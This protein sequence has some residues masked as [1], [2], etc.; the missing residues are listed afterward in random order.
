M[1]RPTTLLRLA[2]PSDEALWRGALAAHGVTAVSLPDDARSLLDVIAGDARLHGARAMVVDL[3][4]LD[5]IGHVPVRLAARLT[6]LHPDLRVFAR[7]P[8]RARACPEQRDWARRHGFAG[9]L[10]GNSARHAA[11]LVPAL[12]E[13][14]ESMGHGEVD[15]A[16]ANAF[17]RTLEVK[18]SGSSHAEIDR[19]YDAKAAFEASGTTAAALAESLRRFRAH[20]LSD[21][22]WRGRTYRQCFVASEA[23]DWLARQPGM[24]RVDAVAA[25][26]MLQGFGFIHHVV[27]ERE[28]DDANL[29]FRFDTDGTGEEHDLVALAE[30]MRARLPTADR[31]YLGRTYPACFTGEDAVD[32]I[33]AELGVGIG[34]AESLGQRLADLSVL[35]HVTDDHEFM[36]SGYFY[37]FRGF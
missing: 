25:G 11:S 2:T 12:A 32:W 34:T 37:A 26:R 16:H 21:R 7:L 13:V 6:R 3:P 19:A 35:R 36:D 8:H 24:S 4:A 33:A 15:P 9:L 23:V 18:R 28:F 14:L 1:N 22:A 5:R 27:R 17:I 31:T 30:S 20:G 10:A 29:F